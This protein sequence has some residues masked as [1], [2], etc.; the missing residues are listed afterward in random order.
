MIDQT[1]NPE[2]VDF[3]ES[4]SGPIKTPA[5]IDQTQKSESKQAQPEENLQRG[6]QQGCEPK[7]GMK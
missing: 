5:L 4:V 7:C 3:P 6:Q 2:P 1:G